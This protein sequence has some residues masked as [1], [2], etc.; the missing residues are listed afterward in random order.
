MD[1]EDS[2]LLLKGP[3]L[4][5]HHLISLRESTLVGCDGQRGPEAP[6]A[7]LLHGGT[8]APGLT[9]RKQEGRQ[10]EQR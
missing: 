5:G 1:V 2:L 10:G 3:E 7:L 9:G 6:A 8:P 4:I